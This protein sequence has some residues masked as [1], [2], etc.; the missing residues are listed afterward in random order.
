MSA[1]SS[2]ARATPRDPSPHPKASRQGCH[3]PPL[4]DQI[5][6]SYLRQRHHPLPYS[7]LP[8]HDRNLILHERNLIL[9]DC[10]QSSHDHNLILHGR[11]LP[12]H[13][14]NQ[15]LRGATSHCTS[16]TRPCVVAS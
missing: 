14:C 9:H 6:S 2:E 13:D 11:N 16:A 7:H 5:G 4:A 12:L 3:P 8:L 10:N 1:G 15:T